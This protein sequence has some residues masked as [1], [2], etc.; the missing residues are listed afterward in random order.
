MT[1]KT[2]TQAVYGL[3]ALLAF[4]GALACGGNNTQEDAA[5]APDASDF[6]DA[7]ISIDAPGGCAGDSTQAPAVDIVFP[8]QDALTDEGEILVRGTALDDGAI[9]DI[10]IN[11]VT[12]QTD[13]GFAS[14]RALVPLTHG[15]ND[16]V[17]TSRDT[18][19][20]A[21][22]DAARVYVLSEP[23]ILYWPRLITLDPNA[24]RA[25]VAD[26]DGTEARLVSVDLDTGVRILVSGPDAGTG[27]AFS[28]FFRGLALDPANG[29]LLLTQQG[30][31]YIL[32]IDIA[33]GA[34]TPVASPTVGTG[35]TV[36]DVGLIAMDG[37]RDRAIVVDRSSSSP[38]LVAVDMSTGAR[39]IVSDATTGTGPELGRILAM[40]VDE[41][42]DRVFISQYTASIG[43]THIL[44]V[45]LTSGQRTLVAVELGQL[46]AINHDPANGR[47]VL[48]KRGSRSIVSLDIATGATTTIS[49]ATIGTGLA[50]DAPRDMVRDAA[51]NRALV[52]DRDLRRILAVDMATGDRTPFAHSTIGAGPGTV[53]PSTVFA[54][55]ANNRLIYFFESLMAIDMTTGVHSTL[56][57]FHGCSLSPVNV[58]NLSAHNG[59]LMGTIRGILGLYVVAFDI[60]NGTC[61]V[62]SDSN[63]GIGPGISPNIHGLAMDT[64]NDRAM[65]ASHVSID[66]GEFRHGYLH[67]VDLTTGDRTMVASPNTSSLTEPSAPVLDGTRAL[68]FDRPDDDPSR[69][70]AI[71]SSTGMDTVFSGDNVGSGPS[72]DGYHPGG[73]VIDR[74]RN[75]I[76]AA[77]DHDTRPALMAIDLN[78][79]NREVLSDQGVGHGPG[80]DGPSSLSLSTSGAFVYVG[81]RGSWEILA[82]DTTTGERVIVAR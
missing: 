77:L 82:I 38:G 33:T 40:T 19:G 13:D 35:P 70:V 48:L 2:W 36:S 12:A 61:V 16:L 62:I 59:Q 57:S 46:D 34:R 20:N 67:W 23:N 18:Q 58:W 21:S 50:L 78:T 30:P 49:D 76:I 9:A 73:M 72:L 28:G 54:D 11:G 53:N 14:W 4:A 37:A 3:A 10:A 15:G 51:H 32:A 24:N 26:G 8:P 29:R 55:E 75:Q 60:Q 31:N 7:G 65:I 42:N 64:A 25:Y 45:D 79:G 6:P 1:A 47:L 44:A 27:D 43:S 52:V 22:C 5:L 71:D 63:T 39:A 66:G 69:I 17:V 68:V 41:S 74:A 56:A 81:D 80:L